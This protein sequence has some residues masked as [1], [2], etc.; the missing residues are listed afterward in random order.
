[1]DTFKSAKKCSEV[2]DLK[3]HTELSAALLS[4]PFTAAREKQ[5]LSVI[6]GSNLL[7]AS[8]R[9]S[10]GREINNLQMEQ[11]NLIA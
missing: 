11:L 6:A 3:Q 2:T 5:P 7:G 9:H 1:M 4:T 10:S 8:R